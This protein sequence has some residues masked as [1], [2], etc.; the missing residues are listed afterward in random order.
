MW[1]SEL[2]MMGSPNLVP[3]NVARA[4]KYW[5]SGQLSLVISTVS[6]RLP[7]VSNL[8]LRE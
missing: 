3:S 5:V 8:L 7:H 6:K 1:E 2:A 4:L